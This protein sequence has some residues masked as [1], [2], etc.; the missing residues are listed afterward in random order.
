MTARKLI[1]FDWALKKLL[2]SKANYEVLEGFLSEL[3]KD[4]IEILEILESESNRE[5]AR[6]K[7]NRVDLKVKNQKG[8]MILIKVQYEWEFDFFQRIL[9]ATAKAI[10]EHMARSDLYANVVKL[11]SIN[12]LYFDLG[13]GRDY[14]YHGAT[15]FVGTHYHDELLL[16]EKQQQLFGKE[17]PHE[18]YPEYYLLKINQ[19][20]DVARDTLDEWIYFLKNEE[21]KGEFQARGLEKAREV[22][23]IMKL[24]E[25]ERLA[26]E[27]H[28]ED[29]RYQA[30]M[31]RS[32]FLDGLFEGRTE[33]LSEG[34][35]EGLAKG[36]AEGKAEEKRQFARMMKENGESLEKIVAYTQ[37]TPEEIASL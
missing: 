11:I 24:S 18:L 16:N 26:Y 25:N 1:S 13:Y 6:D 8:E 5:Q 35:S 10:T 14:I 32:S 4:D 33:G 23:D 9:F 3:L 17:Y 31:F 21:I 37:L 20:D 27:R 29:M 34:L 30:S 19:F 12:I 36:K 7:L 28:I 22:L 15:R 2:R